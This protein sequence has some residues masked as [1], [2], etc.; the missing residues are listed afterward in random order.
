MAGADD[1]DDDG[2]LVDVM[3][4][5]TQ[6]MTTTM[7]MT[8]AAIPTAM[9]LARTTM[10]LSILTIRILLMMT[11]MRATMPIMKTIAILKLMTKLLPMTMSNDDEYKHAA[12]HDITELAMVTKTSW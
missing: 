5:L 4:M 9:I 11:M 1:G 7:A 2:V 10:L 3:T 8:T 12:A 6:T